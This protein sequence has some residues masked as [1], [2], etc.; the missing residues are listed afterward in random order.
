MAKQ[1]GIREVKG[2]TVACDPIGNMLLVKFS[3]AGGS[4]ACVFFPAHIVFW[5]LEHMPVNQD[6]DL[7]PPVHYPQI[8][9]RDWDDHITPRAV[10]VKCH[11]HADAVTMQ[12]ELDH[13]SPMRLLL[14]RTN[15]E[16]MRQFLANYRGDLMDLGVF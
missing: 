15:V 11:Q 9:Q 14:N 4:D 8:A 7:P 13:K 2:L 3:V 1:A 12:L 16:A 6:P 5:L 10:S